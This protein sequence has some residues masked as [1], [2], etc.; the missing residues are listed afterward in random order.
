M[1]L[2]Q[3]SYLQKFCNKDLYSNA[4]LHSESTF[5]IKRVWRLGWSQAILYGQ[6]LTFAFNRAFVYLT[7]A[8]DAVDTPVGN[9]SCRR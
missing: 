7:D 8:V 6:I 1:K 4:Q 9:P 2:Y 5:R 3:N